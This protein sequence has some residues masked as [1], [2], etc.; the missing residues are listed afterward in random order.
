MQKRIAGPVGLS[1]ELEEIAARIRGHM[2]D[3]YLQ[4]GREFGRR[5]GACETM[6][7]GWPSWSGRACC[8]APASK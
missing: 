7:N 5:Q 2:T 4:I 3:A 1:P 6:E 8:R